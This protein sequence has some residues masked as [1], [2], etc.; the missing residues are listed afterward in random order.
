M[1]G[2]TALALPLKPAL[3]GQP[4]GRAGKRPK[5]QMRMTPAQSNTRDIPKSPSPSP[6]PHP[7]SLSPIPGLR[8]IPILGE[9]L[10]T[11]SPHPIPEDPALR[12][13]RDGDQGIRRGLEG[14]APPQAPFWPLGSLGVS[15]APGP[16]PH[17]LPSQSQP[18]SSR[19]G[20]ANSAPA[21]GPLETRAAGAPPSIFPG[22]ARGP[23]ETEDAKGAVFIHPFVHSFL[24]WTNNIY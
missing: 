19:P 6:C 11:P 2:T 24:P 23:Q 7:G 3:R 8:R 12:K 1:P 21:Q 20:L 17:S 14:N 4:L 15:Q 22:R 10:T 9:Q 13:E 16:A 5:D 18:L